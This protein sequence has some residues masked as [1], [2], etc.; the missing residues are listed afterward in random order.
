MSV[1]IEH[2]LGLPV[3]AEAI[4]A[5][6]SDFNH[7]SEWNPLYPR[8]EGVLRIGAPLSLDLALPGQAVRQIKPVILDWVPND[9]IH[10]RLSLAGGLVKTIRYLEIEK[11]SETGCI[12]SNGEFFRGPLAGFMPRRLKSAMRQGFA[13]MGEALKR[14]AEASWRR[15]G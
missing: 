12:F 5:V 3:P 7:W 6:I 15:E 11:L 14:K 1:K 8:A 13:S 4:W 10:W 9:Q 2:R